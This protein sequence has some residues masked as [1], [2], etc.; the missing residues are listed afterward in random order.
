LFHS[1]SGALAWAPVHNVGE[2]RL[3]K[4]L[5]AQFGIAVL[6]FYCKPVLELASALPGIAGREHHDK[7]V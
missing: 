1:F 3:G 7:P 6:G 4:P 5:L 2:P